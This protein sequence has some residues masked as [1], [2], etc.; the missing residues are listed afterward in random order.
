MYNPVWTFYTQLLFL[1]SLILSC[2]FIRLYKILLNLKFLFFL[3]LFVHWLSS[4]LFPSRS[5][6][7]S[8]LYSGFIEF[9]PCGHRQQ[10]NRG[11]HRQIYFTRSNAIFCNKM[12]FSGLLSDF[13]RIIRKA[14]RTQMITHTSTYFLLWQPSTFCSGYLQFPKFTIAPLILL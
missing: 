10:W 2:Y 11:L 8:T 14:L 9:K 1:K 7:Q 12:L 4:I 13:Y 5:I 3:L 6:V